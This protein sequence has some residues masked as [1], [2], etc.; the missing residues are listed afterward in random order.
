MSA[1]RTTRRVL[2]TA[3]AS[4]AVLASAALPAAAADGHGRGHGHGHGHGTMDRHSTI[5]IGEVQY[6]SP[7]RHERTNHSLNREW[8]EVKNTGK[9]A[10][11]LRG[12][13]LTDKEGNRYRFRGLVL[14]GH[15]AVKVHTGKGKD[16]LRDVYQDRTNYVW[17]Q[18]DAAT[19]RNDH[20]RIL[21][22]QSWGHKGNGHGKGKGKGKGHSRGGR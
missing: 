11:D 16:T 3:V 1:S 6:D 7:G 14:G 12:Y 22:S 18:R 4:V 13:T 9:K 20:G 5:M 21:D 15:S 17:D 10:V 19:L 8:V 2:A